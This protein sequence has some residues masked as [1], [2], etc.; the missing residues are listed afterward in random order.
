M[1]TQ[2]VFS[3]NPVLAAHTNTKQLCFERSPVWGITVFHSISEDTG[4]NTSKCTFS[5]IFLFKIIKLLL[6]LV[7]LALTSSSP[8][9]DLSKY[10]DELLDFFLS[11]S[12]SLSF[13]LDFFSY[14]L[15]VSVGS[16]S[17]TSPKI[18]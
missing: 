16:Y 18:L 12:L 14:P 4:Q 17:P 15:V 1:L 3:K 10:V 9:V 6:K 13:D 8:P 5:P 2:S 11:L 7:S